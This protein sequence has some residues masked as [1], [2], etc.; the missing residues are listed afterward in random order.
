M[1]VPSRRERHRAKKRR[2]RP[3]ERI[4]RVFI[5][6][7]VVILVIAGLGY[8]YFRYQWS[9]VA[10]APCTTCVAAAN[11][12]PYNV[13]LIG[14]DSRVGETAAEAQQFGNQSNAGG[15]R[16]D[17]IKIVHVNPS[18][19]TA[20]SMSIPRDTYVTLS[21]L[22]ADS[23]LSSQNKINS[24]FSGGPDALI[25][26][27][28]NTFGISIS[29]YIVINFF[30]LQ[31]AV[32]ALGGI[33]MDF[34]YPVRDRDCQTGVCYN[35][36][37]LD[38]PTAGC[39]VLD[40]QQALAL[41]RSRFYQYY[42]NGEWNYDPSSDLGR[43]T[44]QNLIISAAL[45]KARST[46]NPLSLNSLLTSVVH[47]FSKDDALTPN[48]LYALAERFHAFSGSQ[49]QAYT[50]PTSPTYTSGGSAVEVVE[51]ES[52]SQKIA[53]FLGGPFGS[54]TT[55]PIDAYGNPLALTVPT[56]T[57]P[58]V[59]AAPPVTNVTSSGKSTPTTSPAAKNIPSYDP[60]PC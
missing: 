10:S 48:D 49:L 4:L 45:D 1:A 37:G 38:I 6:L 17:T 46:Y 35:N 23:Q 13:L 3:A 57:L 21:G 51:P 5:V 39:Q 20:S 34:A 25:Q 14:S 32:N 50:L 15:Q 36:S 58:P 22:P 54:I 7:V 29:H 55:P 11:G 26:T 12:A 31:D 18:T 2:R 33:K 53:Q 43:I 8:G 56:T 30:G 42:A 52:A 24:A 16:S 59:S 44:R 28:Q 27:I 41:S 19:G 60:R 9:K 47:D 40:G